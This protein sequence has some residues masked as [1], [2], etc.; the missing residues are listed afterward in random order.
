MGTRTTGTSGSPSNKIND[1]HLIEYFNSKFQ[2]NTGK[3]AFQ[4]GAAPSGGSSGSP[5]G[6]TATGGVI[7]DYLDPSPGKVWRCHTFT[8]SGTF[9]VTAL[10]GSY[11]AAIEWLVVAGGAGGGGYF[12]GSDGNGGGGAGGLRTNSPECPAP[13]KSTDID[14]AVASYTI[15]VGA[16]GYGGRGNTTPASI[17]GQGSPS[18]FAHPTSPITTAGGGYGG[19]YIPG[20]PDG[21]GRDG[22]DG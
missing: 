12:G 6:H 8:S 4:P 16:G 7:S 15:T 17:G 1:G 5:D 3:S 11:P 22:G 2:I 19:S 18:V 10:S 21:T 14:V 9:D 13:L 20:Y